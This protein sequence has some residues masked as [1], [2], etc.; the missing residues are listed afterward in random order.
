M[1]Y[2]PN[3]E[4]WGRGSA[5]IHDC[6]EK[7]PKM[8]MWVTGFTRDGLAKCQYIDQRKKRTIYPNRLAV[9]HDPERFGMKREWGE[10]SQHYFEK[11]IAE[12]E[13]V[14]LWNHYHPIGRAVRT[15]SADGGFE[16]V[17]TGKAFMLGTSGSIYLERGGMWVL[18]FVQPIREIGPEFVQ[19]VTQG[20]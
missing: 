6:D 12:W 4:H 5:V 18:E 10:L 15:T 20:L 11:L 17:T 8:L 16:T 14:R 2:E 7:H 9:L 1:N 19:R 13:R 3:T